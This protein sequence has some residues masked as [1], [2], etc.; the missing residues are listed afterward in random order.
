MDGFSRKEIEVIYL[1]TI[2]FQEVYLFQPLVS[3]SDTQEYYLVMNVISDETDSVVAGLEKVIQQAEKD[4]NS[5]LKRELPKEYVLW[6]TKFQ[7][8]MME[9]SIETLEKM[10]DSL[11]IYQISSSDQVNLP[12][13]LADW[14]LPDAY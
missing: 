6:M 8:Q 14:A 13:K 1:A 11:R 7:D 5:F 9:K 3:G 12:Q 10:K 4:K 2:L